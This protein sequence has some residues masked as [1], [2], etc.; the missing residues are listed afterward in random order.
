LLQRS[1]T[2]REEEEYPVAGKKTKLDDG[3]DV[4]AHARVDF[5]YS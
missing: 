5:D 3:L 1:P 2:G 4:E